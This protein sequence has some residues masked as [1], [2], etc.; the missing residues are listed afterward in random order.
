MITHWNK[1]CE[2]IDTTDNVLSEFIETAS[3]SVS[4]LKKLEKFTREWNKSKKMAE[5][6]DKFITPVEI[7]EVES[8]FGEDIFRFAWK[9]WK[10]YLSEQHGILMRSRY[11]Q[12][13]LKDLEEISEG[14]VDKAISYIRRSMT[15][16]WRK[17]YPI[18]YNGK[19]AFQI[20]KIRELNQF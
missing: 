5:D 1:I 6:F 15:G 13:S 8:P 2:Q 4:Q 9:M 10:E 11:E 3:L 7:I 19:E 12:A 14:N 20:E 17:I 16:P 18:E